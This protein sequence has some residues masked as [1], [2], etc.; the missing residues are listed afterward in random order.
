M[1]DARRLIL[2]TVPTLNS[3]AGTLRLFE[4]VRPE[5]GWRL[6]ASGEPVTL[7]KRGVAWGQVFAR[8]AGHGEPL[9][10]EGDKR[11][12]AG[13]YA[14][15]AP[16]G[17]A[18]SPLA[19]YLQLRPESVCVE[20]PS[21]P[22]YNTITSGDVVGRTANRENMRAIRLYRRG[23]VVDYPTDAAH[24]AGSCIFIHIQKNSTDGTNGCLTLPEER[25][26]ALQKFADAHATVLAVIPESAFGRLGDCLPAAATAKR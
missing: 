14:V 10:R 22:A 17:F 6:V 19:R 12:P 2:V 1:Q 13:F 18:A 9:K 4:R 21:S 26:A 8:L 16:F 11:T 7:G 15:G 5:T 20:D 25:V 3:S 24:R 23:L